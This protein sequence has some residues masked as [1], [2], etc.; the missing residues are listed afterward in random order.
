[1]LVTI[2]V[3]TRGDPGLGSPVQPM[4][5]APLI[6]MVQATVIGMIFG[7]VVAAVIVVVLMEDAI[8][9]PEVWVESRIVAVGPG[10]RLL[11]V[12]ILILL[13][14]L[15]GVPKVSQERSTPSSSAVLILGF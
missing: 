14:V 13:L 8:A 2:F 1:M 11:W 10:T 6:Q 5:S 12:L 3:E 4:L 15:D 7:L 9:V